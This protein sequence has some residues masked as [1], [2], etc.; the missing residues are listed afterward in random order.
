[1]NGKISECQ[2]KEELITYLYSECN[3]QE[4]RTFQQHLKECASCQREAAEFGVVRKS[5]QSWQ[6]AESPRIVLDLEPTAPRS[7]RAIL[8]E[9]A[10]V[11]PGWF[12]YGF[13]CAA[14]CSVA[15]VMLAVLHTQIHYD[16]DGFSA[17]I[18]LVEE[19]KPLPAPPTANTEAIAREMVARLIS[20]KEAQL[21]QQLSEQRA[22]IEKELQKQISMLNSEIEAKNSSQLSRAALELK[23]QHREELQRALLELER[24]RRG[25]G[26][27]L[28]DDP[29]NLWGGI[30][31]NAP[32]RRN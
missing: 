12:K 15:L 11:L 19:S 30:D 31:D 10:A 21:D 32:N 17:K 9:L 22:Q 27:S 6:V 24:H 3:E 14:A 5:L 13:A 23:R 4:Q 18:A 2:R 20:E 7:L 28:D 25:E 16:K 29:F 26:N 1:M 8:A